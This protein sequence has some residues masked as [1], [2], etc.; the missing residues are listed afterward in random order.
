MIHAFTFHSEAYADPATDV[1]HSMPDGQD[2]PV[3][4]GLGL[5]M[6]LFDGLQGRGWEMPH[7]WATDYSHAFEVRGGGERFDVMVACTDLAT[8]AWEVTVELRTGLLRRLRRRDPAALIRL[9]GALEAVLGG[10]PDVSAL[11]KA[12]RES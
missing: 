7:R 11:E 9:T 2:G 12:Q 4:Q 6:A 10:N 1:G 3:P 8:R 5:T